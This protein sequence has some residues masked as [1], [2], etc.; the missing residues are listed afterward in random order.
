MT[1][2][3]TS[4]S[5]Q[6]LLG[7]VSHAGPFRLAPLHQRDAE[8]VDLEIINFLQ[9]D[10]R[11]PFSEIARELDISE[12][13]I[14]SRVETLQNVSSLDITVVGDPRALGYSRGAILGVSLPMEKL[15][16][17]LLEDISD[18]QGVSY[19]IIT[20]GRFNVLLEA[21]FNQGK[22]LINLCEDLSRKIGSGARFEIFPY[23]DV[24][25]QQSN[26]R[27]TF[28]KTT[29]AAAPVVP[30]PLQLNDI[31]R[32][33]IKLLSRDG[34]RS[35][36]SIAA[37]LGI[38]EGQVRQRYRRLYKHNAVRVQA[39]VHPATLGYNSLAWVGVKCFNPISDFVEQAKKMV[40]VTYAATCFG[41]FDVVLE[42][43]AQNDD[44]LFSIINNELGLSQGIIRTETFLSVGLYYKRVEPRH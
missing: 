7:D 25:Y 2:K 22:E 42:V 38:S 23:V 5:E 32:S 4:E 26:W 28:Q 35:F 43:V 15:K 31:D 39:L 3:N 9:D 18:A 20:T 19:V 30:T 37:D 27:Q 33:I 6:G 21:F 36:R 1:R 16:H 40:G 11:T 44:K 8:Q 13:L 14:S 34:R 10:G 12:K 41:R 24:H 29:M 17:S